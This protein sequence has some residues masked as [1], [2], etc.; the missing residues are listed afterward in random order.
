MHLTSSIKMC[1]VKLDWIPKSRNESTH[2]QTLKIITSL[3][4][5]QMSSLILALY[6]MLSWFIPSKN[7]CFLE[8]QCVMKYTENICTVLWV[9]HIYALRYKIFPSPR[10]FPCTN[11]KSVLV[12]YHS[13]LLTIKFTCSWMYYY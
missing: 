10:R 11:I 8:V 12:L 3:Q 7:Q 13:D 2:N 4:K 1:E 5:C 6:I 9:G